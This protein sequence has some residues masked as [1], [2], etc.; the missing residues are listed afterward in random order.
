MGPLVPLLVG[1]GISLLS[2]IFGAKKQASAAKDAARLQ[3]ESANR[4]MAL[5]NQAYAPYLAAGGQ[6]ASVLGGL[7][8]PG[9]PYQPGMMPQ[10]RPMMPGGM[11]V[12]RP[13]GVMSR[14]LTNPFGHQRIG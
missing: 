11:A 8:T 4:A 2:N 13:G 3:S 14:V 7:M 12:P 6:A 1:G 5:M 9:V 10:A